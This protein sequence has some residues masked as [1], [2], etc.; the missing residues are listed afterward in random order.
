MDNKYES[1]KIEK[2]WQEYWEKK[3][4]YQ[5]DPKSNKKFYSIDTPPPT[6]S[7]KMHIGHAF[8]YSQGD[9]I[10][11]FWRM[12]QGVFYP[13][14]TDDNGLPT[15]KL[16]ETLKKV[17]SKEMS[18]EEF[19]KL[20]LKTL[21][22]ITPD[23]VQDWK[24]L[25]ISC[26]YHKTYST[27]DGSSRK[28][29][30]KYFIEL[31]KKKLVYRKTFPTIWDVKFQTPVA[32]AE[33]EDKQKQS[34]FS[35]LKFEVKA[36]E[37]HI[38]TT[39]PELLGACVAVFVHPN[40]DRYR[41]LI[42]KKARVPLFNHEVPIIADKS[43]NM[44]KG[45][46]ALM[47]CSYGDKYD[48]DA[49]SRYKL[50]PR[51]I[52]NKDG[53]LNITPYD[54]L[55]IKKAREKILEDLKKNRMI[56]DQKKIEHT[57]N[58]YEKSGEEIE[59]LPTE[60]WFIKILDKKKQLIKLGEKIKWHPEFMFKRYKNWVEGLEWDW[61]VS[62]ER[63]FG[64]PTPFWCCP[65]CNGIITPEDEELP[66]DPIETKKKCPNC[67]VEAVPETSVLDT[68]ATSSLTPQIASSLFGNKIK[69]PYSL[70]Q[71]AHDIIRTWT[72]Y[73]IVRA[74][75]HEGEIPWKDVMVSGFVTLDGKKMSKSK[76]NVVDPRIAMKKYGSDC[77]RFL[78]AGSKLGE[79]LDYNE[80]DLVAG[81]RFLTKLWNASKL[82]LTF[83]KNYGEKRVEFEPFDRYFLIKL[84]SVVKEA[85]E[86]FEKYD[87]GQAKRAVDGFFWGS[88][89]D[90]YLEIAKKRLYNDMGI[91]TESAKYTLH[92]IL[93]TILKL[94]APIVPHI[95][96]EIYNNF[97]RGSIHTSSWPEYESLKDKDL[98]GSGDLALNVVY[99]VRKFKADIKKSL[100]E[101]ILLTLDDKK[102]EIFKDDLES[103]CHAEIKFGKEF[104]V[105]MKNQHE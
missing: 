103:V 6:V 80:K 61:S 95:T 31:Y 18:R 71:Q 57:V 81:E 11:R 88:F 83:L 60:Q 102:L 62:R 55:T 46:G 96:E 105:E 72:F 2:K 78:A 23:F 84:D 44:E 76:G 13:F 36:H 32:Q 85:T 66:V 38:A 30:Q 42:G 101:E 92:K 89:C 49:I 5:F 67:K 70:R 17:K 19:I 4:I 54:G 94:Y 47:V 99:Q 58:V 98:E 1:G 29:S 35:T 100:K 74:Y 20:C 59:F 65:K 87:F 8:S 93:I 64:V 52:I 75:L 73:T 56:V 68:W 48:V 91:K 77:L 24:D 50:E 10:A 37:L 82:S 15:E 40:D 27:I 14:G 51:I 25:G 3:K 9:F 97:G 41:K 21:E 90:N 26:D 7:G 33:L 22:E 45:T 34:L 53:T 104:K 69:I 28:L 43:S 16:I 79:D 63:H 12:N 86:S 39:R